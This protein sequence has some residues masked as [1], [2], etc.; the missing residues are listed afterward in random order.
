MSR[1]SI[2]NTEHT[3]ATAVILLA[4]TADFGSS[5][6]LLLR[7]SSPLSQASEHV[8]EQLALGGPC[9][10][11]RPSLRW[12]SSAPLRQ[13]RCRLPYSA[14]AV[15]QLPRDANVAQPILRRIHSTL[16][17]Q[18]RWHG[19]TQPGLDGHCAR[20]ESTQHR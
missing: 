7:F 6:V 12:R 5:G 17:E 8:A 4:T 1:P 18:V 11:E 16:P 10:R 20:T 13:G 19:K 3:V 15:A 14:E 2:G 9:K